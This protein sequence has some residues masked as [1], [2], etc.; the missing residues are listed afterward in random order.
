MHRQAQI[1][2]AQQ[3]HAQRHI[4]Q[5]LY[6]RC[7]YRGESG[8][9]CRVRRVA[10]PCHLRRMIEFV[11]PL[12]LQIRYDL[13][14]AGR[15]SFCQVRAEAALYRI[16]VGAIDRQCRAVAAALRV[17]PLV[18]V[19]IGEARQRREGDAAQRQ[20]ITGLGA[21]HILL[22]AEVAVGPTDSHTTDCRYSWHSRSGHSR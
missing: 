6:R 12:H 20:R 9:A 4:G 3:R 22:A 1:V 8:L 7:P 5:I 16:H 11:D 19:A 14:V 2:G 15:E 13:A 17:A 10:G 21:C 18:L